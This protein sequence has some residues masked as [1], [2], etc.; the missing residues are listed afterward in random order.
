MG[1]CSVSWCLVYTVTLLLVFPQR[2]YPIKPTNNQVVH[3]IRIGVG[4]GECSTSASRKEM[5]FRAVSACSKRKRAEEDTL[6]KMRV[7]R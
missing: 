6:R 3:T 1:F 2:G 5:G 7:P 4:M